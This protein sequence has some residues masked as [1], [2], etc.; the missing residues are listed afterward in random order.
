MT[1]RQ[2]AQHQE[3]ETKFMPVLFLQR[4]VRISSLKG[5]LHQ[6][7][8]DRILL[9]H[10]MCYSI[11]MLYSENNSPECMWFEFSFQFPGRTFAKTCLVVLKF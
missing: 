3:P 2:H 5:Q 11:E 1:V 6:A 10:K 7:D 4:Y 9:I 8:Q